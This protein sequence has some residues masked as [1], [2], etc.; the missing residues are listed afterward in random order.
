[1]IVVYDKSNDNDND[2][3]VDDDDDKDFNSLRFKNKLTFNSFFPVE[4]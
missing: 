2:N 4:I 3:D 1:M